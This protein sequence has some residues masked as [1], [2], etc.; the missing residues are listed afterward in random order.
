MIFFGR[1]IDLAFKPSNNKEYLDFLEKN[2]RRD[3][4]VEM[5]IEKGKRT[6]PQNNALHLYFTQLARELNEAGYTVKKV[7][8]IKKVDIDWNEKLVKELLWKPIQEAITGKKSTTDL[9]KS[10]EIDVTYEHM[11]RL[12][13]EVF[14]IHVPFPKKEKEEFQVEVAYPDNNLGEQKF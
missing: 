6:L 4:W 14:H 13:S 10:G 1:I 3:A 12:T 11:N 5:G 8:E 7:M 2:D 9:D